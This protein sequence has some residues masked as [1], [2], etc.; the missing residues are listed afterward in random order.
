MRDALR[1]RAQHGLRMSGLFLLLSHTDHAE[2]EAYQAEYGAELEDLAGTVIYS[3]T[4]TYQARHVP[5]PAEAY[6]VD[7]YTTGISAFSFS[8]NL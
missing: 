3:S 4:N 1:L 5:P 6:V 2:Y 7:Q 8:E